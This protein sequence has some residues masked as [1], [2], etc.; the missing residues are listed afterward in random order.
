MVV[1]DPVARPS[2][3]GGPRNTNST[4][5][6]RAEAD[7]NNMPP[8][9]RP[10]SFRRTTSDR[11][12]ESYN[13]SNISR[14]PE[15][16]PNFI[17]YDLTEGR[18]IEVGSNRGRRGQS[19]YEIPGT[20][21][22]Y[23]K[24]LE[25]SKF[26]SS[27]QESDKGSPPLTAET[28]ERQI[29]RQNGD[30]SGWSTRAN[31]GSED[32]QDGYM[33]R[34]PATNR[35]ARS[36]AGENNENVTIKV[37]GQ[38]RVEV[39]G[40]RLEISDGGEVSF[41]RPRNGIGS[42]PSQYARVPDR[43]KT[44]RER[45]AARFETP[46]RGPKWASPPKTIAL[47]TPP[48]NENANISSSGANSFAPT[49]TLGSGSSPVSN[50]TDATIR[51]PKKP[52]IVLK[53]SDGKGLKK[54]SSPSQASYLRSRAEASQFTGEGGSNGRASSQPQY[55]SKDSKAPEFSLQQGQTL[56]SMPQW[57][58]N[59]KAPDTDGVDI[60]HRREAL[61][62]NED[63]NDLIESENPAN[64]E[65]N[66]GREQASASMPNK[67]SHLRHPKASIPAPP[68]EQKPRFKPLD[69]N[70]ERKVL[71]LAEQ[72]SRNEDDVDTD[73]ADSFIDFA[74]S[75]PM[76]SA[77]SYGNYKQPTSTPEGA[78]GKIVA[79][80]QQ[81]KTSLFSEDLIDFSASQ[82]QSILDIQGL[83]FSS[84]KVA[85][86][87][88]PSF[89]DYGPHKKKKE[90]VNV[91]ERQ[92]PDEKL[93]GALESPVDQTILLSRKAAHLEHIERRYA[94]I[95][96]PIPSNILAHLPTFQQARDTS[97]IEKSIEMSENDWMLLISDFN[98]YKTMQAA[99]IISG[100]ASMH[101]EHIAIEDGAG[102]AI[103]D[104]NVSETDSEENEDGDD[105]DVSEDNK[106]WKNTIGASGTSRM[107]DPFT[108]FKRTGRT[109]YMTAP[110]HPL[111]TN[112]SLQTSPAPWPGIDSEKSTQEAH[113]QRSIEQE[114]ARRSSQH[115]IDP[116]NGL[117]NAAY[118]MERSLNLGQGVLDKSDELLQLL[119]EIEKKLK[120]QEEDT[121]SV[122]SNFSNASSIAS[123][124]DSVFSF[125]SGSSI[126]SISVAGPV[127]AGE[128]FVALLLAD[129]MIHSLCTEA[130]NIN[131]PDRFERHLRRMLKDF[132]V[133]L[134]QEAG[135]VQQKHA[136][137]FVRYR[138]RNSAHMICSALVSKVEEPGDS[139][140]RLAKIEIIGQE[141][142]V[143]V[144]AEEIGSDNSNSDQSEE[145][146][147][148]LQNLEIFI[149][150][151]RAL[152]MLRD[153]L[154][155]FV[156]PPQPQDKPMIVG[157]K[158][159]CEGDR[160]DTATYLGDEK[161]NIRETN[162]ILQS[163]ETEHS[164]VRSRKLRWH[165]RDYFS[166]IFT[167]IGLVPQRVPLGKTRI[168]WRCVSPRKAINE[169]RQD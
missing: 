132:A 39:G 152:E 137:H 109:R 126:S 8:Y 23:Y 85:H 133:Q 161:D 111:A 70:D 99:K 14:R 148:N 34:Q 141:R 96:P 113:D 67:S 127:G 155:I 69:T 100:P 52:E 114:K 168:E 81:A 92:A 24:S 77:Y 63:E 106:P 89:D 54:D 103:T 160:Y 16:G 28:L 166:Y 13:G 91:F 58:S 78:I 10:S 19:Y 156:K 93:L 124:A 129:S 64:N 112:E 105:D 143:E 125:V 53:K 60:G 94:Q 37:V 65:Q 29:R 165:A 47:S 110:P 107:D 116:P 4:N 145:E 59:V 159:N 167:Q 88:L 123:L 164:Q 42:L 121:I 27:Y 142:E 75:E 134:R 151:S 157:T 104:D 49:F 22:P 150:T 90:D 35:I 32:S 68:T 97:K 36:G 31:K 139:I 95:D 80:N 153:N 51:R 57:E 3:A 158:N 46:N 87:P 73:F 136:A 43:P 98:N 56:Q 6:A 21:V 25:E 83:E 44:Q 118:E 128:R 135:N 7:H 1:T 162:P 40:A 115:Q 84:P 117:K 86:K 61:G 45:L 108:Y 76:L 120:D 55:A 11:I 5:M 12:A 146:V 130:L 26:K 149:R 9:R 30:D 101:Q 72:N 74:W 48:R 147:D 18:T 144:E 71:A 140:E 20:Q 17:S 138:A 15:S 62:N 102:N 119:S 38:A 169:D 122:R 82:S 79:A 50:L 41:T 131:T 154:R 2:S 163:T 33:Y 66:T